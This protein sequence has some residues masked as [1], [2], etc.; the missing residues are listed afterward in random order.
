[1]CETYI[2]LNRFHS[3][4]VKII[5]INH[6]SDLKSVYNFGM[7]EEQYRYQKQNFELFGNCAFLTKL[8]FFTSDIHV[9]RKIDAFFATN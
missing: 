2:L 6:C 1:M 8:L 5:L 7:N 4:S 3:N 9:F